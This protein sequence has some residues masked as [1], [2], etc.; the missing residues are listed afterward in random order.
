MHS[1]TPFLLLLWEN[2]VYIFIESKKGESSIFDCNKWWAKDTPQRASLLWTDQS[3]DI[4]KPQEIVY[5]IN[6]GL[7]STQNRLNSQSCC[8]TIE[9]LLHWAIILHVIYTLL[10]DMQEFHPFFVLPPFQWCGSSSEGRY[11]MFSNLRL[12]FLFCF[13]FLSLI[14]HTAC[15]VL[16]PIV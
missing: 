8:L 5:S 13:V 12:R 2:C 9:S 1:K 6:F 11:L 3:L 7:V 14:I 4:T 10:L 15:C 16:L